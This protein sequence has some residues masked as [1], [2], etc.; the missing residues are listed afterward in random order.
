MLSSLAL[1]SRRHMN[2]AIMATAVAAGMTGAGCAHV[3]PQGLGLA[4]TPSPLTDPAVFNFALNLEYLE[5]EY[6]MRGVSGSGVP[7]EDIGPNPGG[8]TGGRQ[9]NF[10]TP[11]VREFMAEIANDEHNHV[12]FLRRAIKASPL[13]ELSRPSID[14]EGSFRAAGKAAGLGDNFDP[15]ADENSFLLGAFIFEDVGVTAYNGAVKLLS[16]RDTLEAA[17][18]ILNVEAYHGAL[19]RT[20]LAESG[21]AAIKAA[22]AIS[23][24]RDTLDG[25]KTTE[26]P[27]TVEDGRFII[28]PSDINGIAFTRTPQQVL[29]VVYLSPD[30]GVSKGG[31]FP[32][33]VRGVV[34]HT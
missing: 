31:F 8:V 28:A 18:G 10:T 15:F 33:G 7:D 21:D 34:H 11:Y 30:K 17:A 1:L 2:R 26:Q 6:Y 20:Q 12:R 23:A 29:N 13:I 19:I 27:L 5:A 25:P 22:N 32:N 3:V 14:L 16:G 24:A 9:V 4:L